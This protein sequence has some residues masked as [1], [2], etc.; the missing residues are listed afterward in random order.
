M[1]NKKVLVF[2]F[3]ILLIIFG[4]IALSLGYKVVSLIIIFSGIIILGVLVNNYRKEKV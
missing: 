2:I 1:K 3:G 4:N